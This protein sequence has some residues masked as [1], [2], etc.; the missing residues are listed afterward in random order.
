VRRL[1]NEQ[2]ATDSFWTDTDLNAFIDTAHQNYYR[3]LTDQS[4]RHGRQ[5]CEFINYG[6]YRDRIDFNGDT[7]SHLSVSDLLTGADSGATAIIVAIFRDGTSGCGTCVLTSVTNGPFIDDEDIH[8]NGS[9]PLI[10]YAYARGANYLADY[11]DF[12]SGLEIEQIVACED[13]TDTDPGIELTSCVGYR[14]VMLLQREAVGVDI[15]YKNGDPYRYFF[16]KAEKNI[17]G[18]IFI[19]ERMY[20]APAAKTER[21]IRLHVLTGP[22]AMSSD[23]KTTGLPDYAEQCMVLA[24]AVE[25]RLMEESPSGASLGALQKQLEKAEYDLLRHTKNYERGPSQVQFFDVID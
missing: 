18:S 7:G 19:R 9:S 5:Y 17:D 10:V 22:A 11:Y 6:N 23:T 13:Y 8:S 25:A 15:N 4:G 14:E 3:K 12:N 2:T 1:L 21:K 24:A 20:L 16:E